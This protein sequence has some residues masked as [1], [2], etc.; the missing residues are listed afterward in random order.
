MMKLP[1]EESRCLAYD[2]P[3]PTRKKLPIWCEKRETCLRH[4]AIRSDGYNGM[5]HINYRVCQ[6]GEV[7]AYIEAAPW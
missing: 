1:P 2:Q 5:N 4:L 3:H 7:D 6:V